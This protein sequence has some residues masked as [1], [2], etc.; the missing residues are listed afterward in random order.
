MNKKIYISIGL[1]AVSLLYYTFAGKSEES[2]NLAPPPTVATASVESDIPSH[3]GEI[4][5]YVTGAVEEPG[6]YE[7]PQGTPFGKVLEKAGG[8]LPYADT[9]SI[10]LAEPVEKG[11]HLHIAL[12]FQGKPEELLRKK[13]IPLNTADEKML[14]SLPGVGPAMAKRIV[15]Y[16][17]EKGGFTSIEQLKEVKG[18]GDAIFHKLE[19]EVTLS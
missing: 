13:K 5:V 7:V 4:F 18:I 9:K 14:E 3:E 1:L 6:L 16:R 19:G 2:E 12:D 15:E 10:N 8:L 11:E 17:S